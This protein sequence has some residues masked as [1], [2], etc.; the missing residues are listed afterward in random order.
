MS[1]FVAIKTD[2]YAITTHRKNI[3][4]VK[5]MKLLKKKGSRQKQKS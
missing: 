3:G 4:T 2:L 1:T 5:L